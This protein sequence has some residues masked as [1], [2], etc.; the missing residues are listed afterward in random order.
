MGGCEGEVSGAVDAKEE[1]AG[2]EVEG[3]AVCAG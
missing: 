3:W 2:E 1:G